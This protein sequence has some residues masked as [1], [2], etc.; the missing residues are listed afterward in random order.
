[1][2]T[3]LEERAKAGDS[4]AFEWSV[5]Q[6]L[7]AHA[8]TTDSIS[9]RGT[10]IRPILSML[11]QHSSR[12]YVADRGLLPA[13]IHFEKFVPAGHPITVQGFAS[14]RLLTFMEVE[15]S[16][17]QITAENRRYCCS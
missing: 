15:K 9:R 14:T 4:L 5:W 2:S 8:N 10:G 13:N 7:P 1:M 12:R 6:L 16:E 11:E 17:S 3:Y